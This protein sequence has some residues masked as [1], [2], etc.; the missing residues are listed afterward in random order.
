MS[1]EAEDWNIQS[2]LK[3]VILMPVFAEGMEAWSNG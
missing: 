2:L 3:V 1:L